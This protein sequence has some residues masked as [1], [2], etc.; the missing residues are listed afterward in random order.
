[1]R[2]YVGRCLKLA[3]VSLLQI[4]RNITTN[5]MANMMRY[6]YLR[7]P[8]GRFRNPYDHGLRKNCSDFLI[9]GYNEDVEQVGEATHSDGIGMM[10]MSRNPNLPNGDAHSHHANGN[11]H[12]HVA[13]NVK[14]SRSHPGQNHGH[15]HAYVHSSNCSH[16]NHGKAES[17]PLGL[18]IGLGRNT[19]RSVVAS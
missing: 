2:I 8:G 19:S 3:T 18:G 16:G 17:A 15:G 14:T 7:G 12:G 9:N 6:S 10:Q 5:E 13:I 4:S 11:A 1:M